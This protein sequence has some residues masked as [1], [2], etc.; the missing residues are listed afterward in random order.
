MAGRGPTPKDASKRARRNS[1]SAP[2]SVVELIPVEEFPDLPET[3]MVESPKAGAFVLPFPDETRRWWRNWAESP[4]ARN[5]D[6][7]A[8]ERL[9]MAAALHARAV[10]GDLNSFKEFRLHM[11]L[12][13]ETPADRLRQRIQVA[14]AVDAEI[15][16]AGKVER[17]QS[18]YSRLKAVDALEA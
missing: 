10:L 1:D 16:T 4:F 15:T 6:A 7:L 2:M 14:Q 9:R 13:P 8:W 3:F 17:V 12:F 5:M 11:A 18:R